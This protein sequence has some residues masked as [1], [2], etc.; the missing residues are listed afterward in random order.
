MEKLQNEERTFFFFFL[1]T[2]EICFGSTKMGIFYRDKAEK[3]QSG[4]IPCPLWKIFSLLYIALSQQY[5]R[6]L[7]L[8]KVN[9]RKSYKNTYFGF[10]FTGLFSACFLPFLDFVFD[11][12]LIE[13]GILTSASMVVNHNVHRI[14]RP[15]NNAVFSPHSIQPAMIKRLSVSWKRHIYF[16]KWNETNPM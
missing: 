1:K 10:N 9:T 12:F 6:W 3:T 7:E 14:R 16:C 13:S 5:S 4:K 11:G 15:L 8:I 2:T